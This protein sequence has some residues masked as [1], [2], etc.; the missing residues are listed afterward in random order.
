MSCGSAWGASRTKSSEALD[1]ELPPGEHERRQFRSPFPPRL[2]SHRIS[3]AATWRPLV[4]A[5]LLFPLGALAQN[6][7]ARADYATVAGQ[8]ERSEEHTSELQS[9]VHL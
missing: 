8:L 1:I 3:S 7:P 5:A 6:A 9:P 2:M 4:F